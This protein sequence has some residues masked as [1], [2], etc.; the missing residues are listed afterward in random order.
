MCSSWTPCSF[1]RRQTRPLLWSCDIALGLSQSFKRTIN[2]QSWVMQCAPELPAEVERGWAAWSALRYFIHL[3]KATVEVI[4]KVCN[5]V[6]HF[7]SRHY[8]LI[9]PRFPQASWRQPQTQTPSAQVQ[10]VPRGD[11]QAAQ[12]G[13]ELLWRIQDG[14][15]RAEFQRCSQGCTQQQALGLLGKLH[16]RQLHPLPLPPRERCLCRVTWLWHCSSPQIGFPGTVYFSKC[17]L[18]HPH[19][20]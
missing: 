18:I 9:K 7:Y 6:N 11:W 4:N 14:A 20:W 17:P 5:A 1:V 15:A 10:S 12:E 2:P 19:S 16:P 3:T 8:T 13:E